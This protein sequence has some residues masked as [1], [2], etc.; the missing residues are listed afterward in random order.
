MGR[1]TKSLITILVLAV[2]A[3]LVYNYVKNFHQDRVEKAVE[4][5]RSQRQAETEDLQQKIVDLEK[6]LVKQ[7]PTPVPQ[8]KIAEVFGEAET[9]PLPEREEVSCETLERRIEAF[10][11][12]IDKQAYMAPFSLEESTYD[13][14]QQTVDDLSENPPLITGE[15]KDLSSLILNVAHF[16]RVLGKKRID[17]VKTLLEKEPEIIESAMANFFAWFSACHRCEHAVAPCPSLE[18]LYQYAGFFLNTLAGR[19]YLLRRDAPIRVLTAYYAV[20][21]IDKANDNLVNPHG[22][23]IR[24]YINGS[25]YDMENHRGLVSRKEYME[26]LESLKEKYQ[27]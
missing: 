6:E 3:F 25:L 5:E 20:L 11:R 19:S 16:Y 2:G 26:K 10:F 17:I 23:D 12:Y 24:P 27:M 15:M 9:A 14:F 1:T 8:E 7:S 21:I 22:I 4:K 13:L 18:V